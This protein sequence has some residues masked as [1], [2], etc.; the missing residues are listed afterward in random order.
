MPVDAAKLRVLIPTTNGAVEVLLLTEEDPVIG[1][2]VACVGGTT[3]TA[4]IAAAY[5]AFVVR[6]TGII[7]SLFGHPC[8]RL[9]VSGRID[10]G[11]SW[12]LGVLVAHA[13]HAAGRLAEEN[14]TAGGIIWATGSVRPVDLTVG[15]VSHVPEKLANSIDRLTQAAAAGQRVLVAIPQPNAADVAADVRAD[16]AAHGIEVIELSEVYALADK[17][18]VKL[19]DSARRSG[20]AAPR[21][22]QGSVK[23]RRLFLW[24]A[25]AA[26]LL[27][28]A[29]VLA[30]ALG[31]L[32]TPVAT[33][34]DS[35]PAQ[36]PPAP[37]RSAPPAQNEAN[38]LVPEMVPFISER[39]K[40]TIRD[41]YMSAPGYKALALSSSHIGFV[42]AQPDKAAADTAAVAAC[43][44][45]TDSRRTR[46]A[47]PNRC[48]LYASGDVVVAARGRPP[49]PPRPW[50]IRDASI[51]S[52]FSVKDV[53]LLSARS[54][55]ALEEGDFVKS[56]RPKALA[57]SPTGVYSAYSAESDT[58]DAGRR[59]LE[60]CGYNS[61]AACMIIAVGNTFV[62]P[63]PRS[64]KVVGFAKPGPIKLVAPELSAD[65]ERRLDSATSGW[66]AVAVGAG[67]RP[68]VKL[69][70]ESEQAAIEASMEACGRQDRGCRV[71]V[72]GPFLVERRP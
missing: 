68:G 3:E 59:A 56:S 24:G 61:G 22:A 69:G 23:L 13:L 31:R 32:P 63:I 54:L 48:D 72:I 34:A 7:E 49:M 14:D 37:P 6:P 62:V 44:T 42:T 11:S 39:D 18:A 26:A 55:R 43:Q 45:L 35:G 46:S 8:Y 1:R 17:L 10:A 4:D 5:H 25:G 50:V 21:R 65:V 51:E 29:L 12:Q 20:A 33:V 40:A 9:D 19:P 47:L 52:P 53:P 70:A 38:V 36:L 57:L 58:D 16:L 2:C 71:A 27:C 60:R 64:M 15:G 28:A 41:I 67:G 66:S 30:Y